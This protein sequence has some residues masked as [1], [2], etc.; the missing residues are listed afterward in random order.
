MSAYVLAC[1]GIASNALR[2]AK[3]VI[4]VIISRLLICNEV[5]VYVIM[6]GRGVYA[7][8]FYYWVTD[9]ILLIEEA[10]IA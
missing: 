8:W 9:Y 1:R 6:L 3:L 7:K 2:L 5:L 4:P 10:S